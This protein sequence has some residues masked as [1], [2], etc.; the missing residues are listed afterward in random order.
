MPGDLV[1]SHINQNSMEDQ[2]KYNSARAKRQRPLVKGQDHAFN[3]WMNVV[4]LFILV[5]GFGF[6]LIFTSCR[7]DR[8]GGK[9]VGCKPDTIWMENDIF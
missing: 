7:L 4:V 6:L 1:F 5:F 3:F 2:A 8:I 9:V